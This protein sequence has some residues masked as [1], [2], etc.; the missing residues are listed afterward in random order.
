MVSPGCKCR[1]HF[2]LF[3]IADRDPG[4]G[5]GATSAV[6]PT[7]VGVVVGAGVD[8]R[9]AW[10]VAQ[11]GRVLVVVPDVPALTPVPVCRRVGSLAG[12]HF[13][14]LAATEAVGAEVVGV[15]RGISDDPVIQ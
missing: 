5:R 15:P 13:D 10:T 7:G 11:V 6:D 3:P 1:L 2:D 12:M 14:V 8:Q 9:A 4:T